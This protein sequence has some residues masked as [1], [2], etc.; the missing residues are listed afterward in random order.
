MVVMFSLTCIN[1][2]PSGNK[3]FHFYLCLLS[4]KGLHHLIHRLCPMSPVS[5]RGSSL[6]FSFVNFVS[7][8]QPIE[9]FREEKKKRKYL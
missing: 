5:E 2:I 8:Y 1:L 7:S 6:P 4:S 9:C 3:L